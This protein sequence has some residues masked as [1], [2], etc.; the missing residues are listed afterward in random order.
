MTKPK[1]YETPNRFHI[2]VEHGYLKLWKMQPWDGKIGEPITMAINAAPQ[3]AELLLQAHREHHDPRLAAEKSDGKSTFLFQS[4]YYGEGDTK[5]CEME[6]YEIR[7]GVKSKID[8]LFADHS[9]EAECNLKGGCLLNTIL[10][11]VFD[12]YN[13]L[14]CYSRLP[15]G[16][17]KLI[18]EF[19]NAAKSKCDTEIEITQATPL[20]VRWNIK[21]SNF[22]KK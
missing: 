10:K 2:E 6:L 21:I 15:G 3:L 20:F 18:G 19:E 7:D 17:P 22:A 1:T 5:G 11:K 4:K 13:D 14:P 8:R 16:W 12:N 9:S